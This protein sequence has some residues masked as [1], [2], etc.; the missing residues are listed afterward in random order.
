MIRLI[1]VLIDVI[2]FLTAGIPLFFLEW[3]I[4]LFSKR[5][6]DIS[7]L[8][9]VQ[10]AFKVI[11]FLSG[12]KVTVIG[13]ENVPRDR[14][15]LYVA[16]H[17]SYFDVILTYARTPDLTGYVAKK[18]MLRYPLLRDWMKLLY[19][20]F[21]DRKDIKQGLALILSNVENLKKGISVFVFPEGTRNKTQDVLLP[22]HDGSLKM[23]E[24]SGAP[25]VPVTVVNTEQILEA[26]MPFIR[27]AHVIIEYGAPIETKDITREEKKVL[28]KNIQQI[29]TET[30]QKNVE[31]I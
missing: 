21:L 1:I 14:A 9:I 31:L 11:I 7:S 10:F 12:T 24:K 6:K 8:R 17:R 22:F 18:E 25:I 2:V 15:V 13:E 30:Y 23:A 4:G 29:L 26:H 20:S 19:C 3:I 16:N 27:R 5:G 28:S